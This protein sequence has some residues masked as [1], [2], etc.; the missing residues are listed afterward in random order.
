MRTSDSIFPFGLALSIEYRL[1]QVVG[2]SFKGPAR[3]RTTMH[4]LGS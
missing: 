4:P 1:I 2:S 3:H